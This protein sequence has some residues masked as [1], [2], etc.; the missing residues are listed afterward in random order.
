G[1]QDFLHQHDAQI[2]RA[3]QPVVHVQPIEFLA[4]TTTQLSLPAN[5]GGA[6]LSS[7]QECLSRIAYGSSVV[8]MSS[9]AMFQRLSRRCFTRWHRP[10]SSSATCAVISNACESWSFAANEVCTLDPSK[11][12][13]FT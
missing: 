9:A 4:H 8:S 3:V 6:G 5:L 11:Q 1:K 2:V 7:N 10:P 13:S 12:T